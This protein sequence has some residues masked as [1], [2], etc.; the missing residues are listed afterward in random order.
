MIWNKNLEPIKEKVNI[1]TFP[2][3]VGQKRP[4]VPNLTVNTLLGTGLHRTR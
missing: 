2:L 3:F 1:H 4:R